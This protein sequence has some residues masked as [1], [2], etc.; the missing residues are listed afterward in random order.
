MKLTDIFHARASNRTF[1]SLSSM[2]VLTATEKLAAWE[3]RLCA[4]IALDEVLA[5]EAL[6]RSVVS[7]KQTGAGRTLPASQMMAW[8]RSE[9]D[10]CQELIERTATLINVQMVKAFGEPGKSGDMDLVVEAAKEY[11]AIYRAFLNWSL[12]KLS[13]RVHP[14]FDSFVVHFA[15]MPLPTIVNLTVW[16]A[17]V[18]N[19]GNAIVQDGDSAPPLNLALMLDT[20]ASQAL[21]DEFENAAMI[22]R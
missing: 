9:T 12:D 8:M 6:L 11:G 17:H 18:L 5:S 1:K 10:A 20:N 4:Q 19:M 7:A 16:P 22:S 2:A 3:F 14:N 15:H 13:T 21:L